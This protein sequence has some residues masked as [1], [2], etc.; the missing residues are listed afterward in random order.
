MIVRYSV[1]LW[2][3]GLRPEVNIIWNPGAPGCCFYSG[4]RIGVR[5]DNLWFVGFLGEL[6]ISGLV[7]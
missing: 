1:A 3:S 6:G 2:D 7:G 5:D 4:S